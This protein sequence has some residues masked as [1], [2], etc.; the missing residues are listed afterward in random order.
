MRLEIVNLY[1][2]FRLDSNKICNYLINR[3]YFNI[4]SKSVHNYLKIYKR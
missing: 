1:I 3:E 4:G 2:H